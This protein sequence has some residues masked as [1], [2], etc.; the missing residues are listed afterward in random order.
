M[1]VDI[2]D[3]KEVCK[4]TS[5]LTT[6]EKVKLASPI[7][8]LIYCN[9]K[10]FKEGFLSLE[11]RIDSITVAGIFSTA[12]AKRFYFSCLRLL[13]SG[14]NTEDTHRLLL[15]LYYS[16]VPHAPILDE[17]AEPISAA[18]SQAEFALITLAMAVI[19]SNSCRDENQFATYL[20]SFL[21]NEAYPSLLQ[22]VNALLEIKALHI[23]SLHSDI[24]GED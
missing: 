9:H 3:A 17:D 22:K 16:S 23:T 20:L 19:C 5:A 14:Y 4:L 21:G 2:I 6:E 15:H 10:T 1:L 11:E 18:Y 8:E 7:A 24:L 12:P 13:L